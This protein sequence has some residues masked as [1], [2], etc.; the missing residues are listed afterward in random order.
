MRKESVKLT[1]VWPAS[2]DI[3]VYAVADVDKM[4]G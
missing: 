1:G 4:I 3:D 2:A